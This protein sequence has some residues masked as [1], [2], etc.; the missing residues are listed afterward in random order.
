MK[1][2][3]NPDSSMLET[4]FFLLLP[5]GYLHFLT[6]LNLPAAHAAAAFYSHA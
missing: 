6:A 5:G 1:I 4:P 3:W 2:D